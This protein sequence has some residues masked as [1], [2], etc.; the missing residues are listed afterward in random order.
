MSFR[1]QGNNYDDPPVMDSRTLPNS[2][3]NGKASKKAAAKRRAVSTKPKKKSSTAAE[4]AELQALLL[5]SL[6]NQQNQQVKPKKPS[7]PRK[8]KTNTFHDENEELLNLLAQSQ[9]QQQTPAK[10]QR[11]TKP[12][13]NNQANSESGILNSII[14]N[15]NQELHVPGYNYLGPGTKYRERK[16]GKLGKSKQIPVNELDHAAMIHDAAY[17]QY[18]DI[19]NRT[20]ADH[21]FRQQAQSIYNNPNIDLGQR[22]TSVAAD[23]VFAGKNLIGAGD[24]LKSK[25]RASK[26]KQEV[27]MLSQPESEMFY[28]S[29]DTEEDNDD[30]MKD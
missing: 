7:K 1:L 21:Q 25:P 12:K 22:A 30:E 5:G 6:L 13:A 29:S 14:N 3:G 15:L 10:R 8:S 19:G 11:T 27:Q 2:N 28:D 9:Q 24:F 23:T 16:S 26:K 18:P 17:E 4:D 20:V